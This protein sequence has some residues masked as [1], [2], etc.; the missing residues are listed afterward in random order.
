MQM[1]PDQADR[2]AQAIRV[3]IR[4]HLRSPAVR[5]LARELA[6]LVLEEADRL[7]ERAAEHDSSGAVET[8][9]VLAPDDTGLPPETTAASDS[10]AQ[11]EALSRAVKPQQGG[12]VEAAGGDGKE[13][14]AETAGPADLAGA[15]IPASEPSTVATSTLFPHDEIALP[16]IA[17]RSRLKADACRLFVQRRAASGN[18]A[19]EASV[20]ASM[21][22]MIARAKS[23]PSCFLWV[24][25]RGKEPPDDGQL[26]V[27]AQNY[28]ALAESADLCD[29]IVRSSEG[30][31]QSD[32]AKAFQMMA[33]ASSALRQA[34]RPAWLT[35]PDVD[36]NEAHKWLRQETQG[37]RIFI[38]RY[39]KVTD[40]A[41]PRRAGTLREEIRRLRAGIEQ[42]KVTV[43]RVDELLKKVRYH[44]LRLVNGSGDDHDC[45]RVNDGVEALLEHGI[46][47]DDPRLR[48]ALAGLTV[49]SFPV[50]TP[51]GAGVRAVFAAR[52][53][54]LRSAV[55][56]EQREP[57][58]SA[59]VLE[60]RDLLKGS[61]IVVVGGDRRPE[62]VDRMQEAFG[63]NKVE[64]ISLTEHGS[65]EPLRAP[66][67]RPDTRLVIVLARLTGHHHADEA[68]DYARKADVPVVTMPGGYNP[69]QVA[70][71]V[72]QQAGDRLRTTTGK[73]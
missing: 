24:F 40:P 23:L 17:Q 11:P 46:E 66:I 62:A 29:A 2:L 48:D 63:L 5:A 39:M 52:Q 27:I 32:V 13:H 35:E 50:E 56:Q 26:E 55:S 61:S 58:W 41:D 18:P 21:D 68:R 38:Q 20:Q 28:E 45:G 33:E 65:A 19:A 8:A 42:R 7:D 36:Q 6:V 30:V 15:A 70:E 53:G 34:L 44:V 54:S 25:W 1:M 51:P 3:V 60:A 14:A 72:L 43:A 9:G 22:Q 37:R 73:T 67:L 4:E 64:W 49:E 57:R 16:L 71:Q 69:E 10:E 12:M 31:E 47:P 59:R